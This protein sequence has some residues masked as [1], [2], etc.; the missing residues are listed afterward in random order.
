MLDVHPPHSATHTWR[1]FFIHI[2]TIA[3]GLLIALALEQTVEA[4][5]RHHER[6]RL[7]DDLRQEARVRVLD[8]RQ[9]DRSYLAYENW[10][11][12]SLHAALSATVTSH[13]V[14]FT[15]PSTR[16]TGTGNPEPSTAVWTAAEASGIVSVLTRQEIEDWERVDY[17]AKVAQH[18]AE[19]SQ[20]ALRS[21]EATCA[22]LDAN[23]DP[24]STIRTTSSGR[25]ELTLSLSLGIES[26]ETLRHDNQETIAATEAVLHTPQLA[27]HPQ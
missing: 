23:I 18:D 2:A 7:I 1:D 27:R 26:L 22:H 3:V 19:V 16:A 5:H 4:I 17:F 11:R 25:N 20:A 6:V 12:E 14:V 8:I 24:G 13:S 10:L 21:I 15:L 9:N